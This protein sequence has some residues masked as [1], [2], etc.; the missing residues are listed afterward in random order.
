MALGLFAAFAVPLGQTPFS[1]LLALFV[2]ANL[3]IAA[4][5]TLATNPLTVPFFYY[6]AYRVGA[7]LWRGDLAALQRDPDA[8]LIDQ[9]ISWLITLAGPTYLGLLVFA[10][11]SAVAG[12]IGVHIGWRVWVNWRWRRR[13]EKR[14]A[15][16][17]TSANA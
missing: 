6:M 11:A 9:T 10:L 7:G 8:T 5:A 3:P 17:A 2:R 12:Y 14:Q 15:L 16:P 13:F 4:L 1:A